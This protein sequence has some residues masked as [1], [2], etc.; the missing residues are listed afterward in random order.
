MP[1]QTP[2]IKICEIDPGSRLCAGCGRTLD[3][4]GHW[5]AMSDIEREAV[6]AALPARMAHAGL[7]VPAGVK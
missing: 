3:E 2:C 6:M 5:G 4:I 1:L 7:A